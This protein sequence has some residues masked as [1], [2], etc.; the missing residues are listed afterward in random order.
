ML[1]QM[2][3]VPEGAKAALDYL[4]SIGLSVTKVLFPLVDLGTT[5]VPVYRVGSEYVC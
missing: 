5:A 2:P 4:V 1:M 3:A